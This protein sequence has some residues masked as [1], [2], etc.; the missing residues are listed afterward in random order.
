[1]KPP[2]ITEL[3]LICVFK[4]RF[5]KLSVLVIGTCM[6]RIVTCSWFFFFLN[7]MKYPFFI[8]FD[9]FSFEVHFCQIAA[10]TLMWCLS[11]KMNFL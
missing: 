2:T 4:S 7:I 6:F 1:M 8:F 5:I 9:Y 3:K 10:H 11:L